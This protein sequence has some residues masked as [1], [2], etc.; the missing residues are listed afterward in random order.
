MNE[1]KIRE[2]KKLDE[3]LTKQKALSSSNIHSKSI[4]CGAFFTLWNFAPFGETRPNRNTV[5]SRLNFNVIATSE[6]IIYKPS[7][8]QFQCRTVFDTIDILQLLEIGERLI[9]MLNVKRFFFHRVILIHINFV[10]VFVIRATW[11]SAKK[12]VGALFLVASMLFSFTVD[13]IVVK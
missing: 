4:S 2:K 10:S 6:K 12:I 5:E 1:N 8:I 13:K 7:Q 3:S 9:I 11:K